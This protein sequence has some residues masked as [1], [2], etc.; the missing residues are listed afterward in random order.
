MTFQEGPRNDPRDF[1]TAR[2]ACVH[3]RYVEP[4]FKAPAEGQIELIESDFFAP[5]DPAIKCV[6]PGRVLECTTTAGARQCTVKVT[7]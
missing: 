6:E 4:D 7:P 5:N 2:V 3:A 1:G